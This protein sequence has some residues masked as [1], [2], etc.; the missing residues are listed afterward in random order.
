MAETRSPGEAW[1][2]APREC[3]E[4]HRTQGP[5]SQAAA[6]GRTMESLAS[7]PH[8]VG[9]RFLVIAF[10]ALAFVGCGGSTDGTAAP[11]GKNS[12]GTTTLTTGKTLDPCAHE[13]ATTKIVHFGSAGA[14]L[15]G[16]VLGKGA[17]GVVLAHQLHS[18]LCSWLPFG[19]RLAAAGMR[20]LAFDFPSTSDLDRYV[21]A[22]V[23]ELRRQGAH[24]IA[25]AGASMG[26]TAVLVA[27]SH[28]PTITR[29]AS[30]SGLR[31]FEGLAAGRAVR[32]VHAPTLF[33]AAKEDSPYIE[34]ARAMYHA[35]PG[36]KRLLVVPGFD[37]GTDLLDDGQISDQLRA[38]LASP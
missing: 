24:T 19:E 10:A 20:V 26:G 2:D 22:A 31:V 35:A 23:A 28:D 8:C 18:N 4:T 30:L 9:R 38:F 7:G 14:D 16:V 12:T 25:L 15:D 6:L 27:A 37:H 11:T 5:R 3:D 13:D 1:G 34:D 29:V 17:T 33:I 32:Q 36:D 21:L